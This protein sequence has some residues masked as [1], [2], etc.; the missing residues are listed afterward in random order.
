MK[1]RKA[2]L[3]VATGSILVFA[4]SPGAHAQGYWPWGAFAAGAVTGLVVGATIAR[5]PVYAYPGPGYAFPPPYSV[6]G[7]PGAVVYPAGV[8]AYYGPPPGA[9]YGAPPRVIY[10]PPPRVIYA[11]PPPAIVYRGYGGW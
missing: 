2:L 9:I 5:P 11:P 1:K 7:P 10:A 6:Y 4:G 8:P 3:A